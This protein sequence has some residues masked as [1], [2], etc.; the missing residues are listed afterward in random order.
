[1]TKLKMTE[2]QQVAADF[3][4][5]HDA[6]ILVAPTGEG[7]TV[8]CLTAI[9]DMIDA[10][11]VKRVIVAVPAKVLETDV[12]GR[13]NTK[14][15]HTDGLG[16]R[17]LRGDAATRLHEML[18][19][20]LPVLVVSLNNLDWLLKQNHGADGIIID[21][22]SRASGKWAAGLRT[23]K[24][25]ARFKWRV[26]L[27]AT[28]VSQNFE[29]LFGMSRVLDMGAAFG[30]NKEK[31]MQKYFEQDYNGHSWRIR[32]GSASEILEKISHMV[33]VIPDTKVEKLP[34]CHYH[35]IP[36]TMPA[37]TRAV[38]DDMKAEMVVTLETDSVEAANQAV[39]SGKLRQIAS[40][41][42]YS[43]GVD[44]KP[45]ILDQERMMAA[46]AWWTAL[47]GRPGLIFYEYV[48]QASR[49]EDWKPRNV[50]IAQINSMSHGVDGLQHKF[51]DVL[52]YQPVWSRDA[53]EQAVGRVWRQGQTNEVNVTTLMCSA[54]LDQ[55]VVE[56][57]NGNAKWMELFVK[58]LKGK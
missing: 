31:F 48:E 43:N 34:L 18:H 12:W 57:V 24:Y 33:H 19:D 15:R 37:T 9:K 51:A 47:D 52:F 4:F 41:F 11:H 42:V 54:S 25:G 40:G 20:N 58:H 2:V 3:L 45:V 5:E 6:S 35:D 28:P 49:L 56:R 16:I 10:G 22:L 21:E 17:Q 7:K 50:E 1:M 14:W 53:K 32:E 26:G 39:K 27:T 13:E 36:F 29:K 30:R 46:A 8:I 23:K 38:Y 55:I 44:R